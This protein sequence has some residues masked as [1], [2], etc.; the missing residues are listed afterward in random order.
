MLCTN[1]SAAFPRGACLNCL[2][3][4]KFVLTLHGQTQLLVCAQRLGDTCHHQME[5]RATV[6]LEARNKSN[7]ENHA[8]K[9]C[10][11]IPRDTF[12]DS[13]THLH[14]L[15]IIDRLNKLTQIINFVPR[16]TKH[17]L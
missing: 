7:K 4:L 11:I 1:T 5:V 17:V 15:K 8:D 9:P 13:G 2:G 12:V 10:N 3:S 16:N 6:L 14:Q